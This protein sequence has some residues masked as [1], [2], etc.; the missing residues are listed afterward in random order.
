MVRTTSDVGSVVGGDGDFA[1]VAIGCGAST[2]GP[3]RVSPR[4]T[5]DFMVACRGDFAGATVVCSGAPSRVSPTTP[6]VGPVIICDGDF[7]GVV[8]VIDGV[9]DGVGIVCNGDFGGL[10]EGG[11]TRITEG[12]FGGVMEIFGGPGTR[13]TALAGLATQTMARHNQQAL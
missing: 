10:T 6:D 8:V 3:S 1:G 2:A 5:S 4:P 9:L 7:S 13:S 11:F 12:G